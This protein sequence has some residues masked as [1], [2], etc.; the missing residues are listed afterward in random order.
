ML[1]ILTAN[2]PPILLLSSAARSAPFVYYITFISLANRHIWECWLV[3]VLCGPIMCIWCVSIGKVEYTCQHSIHVMGMAK[4]KMMR[5]KMCL[6]CLAGFI[7]CLLDRSYM[8]CL[9][10]IDHSYRLQMHAYTYV[11]QSYPSTTTQANI[12]GGIWIALLFILLFNIHS[13]F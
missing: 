3:Q 6:A 8:Y 11:C 5:S 1:H 4:Y 7:N 9:Q 2:S 12:L 10:Q 13:F